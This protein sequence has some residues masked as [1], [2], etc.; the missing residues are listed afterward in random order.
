VYEVDENTVRRTPHLLRVVR[1]VTRY[2]HGIP[3]VSESR[4]VHLEGLLRR[5]GVAEGWARCVCTVDRLC[6]STLI[7]VVSDDDADALEEDTPE[8]YKEILGA[9][10]ALDELMGL[11]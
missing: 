6:Y 1:A 10:E 3:Q 7:T 2:A 9:L 5:R 11:Y 4:A 8:T